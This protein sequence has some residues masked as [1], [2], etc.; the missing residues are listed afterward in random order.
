VACW[1]AILKAK[2]DAA[3]SMGREVER[4]AIAANAKTLAALPAVLG[5]VLAAGRCHAHALATDESLADGEIAIRDAVFAE[6]AEE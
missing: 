1:S 5:D 3:V 6:R 4:L 2:S